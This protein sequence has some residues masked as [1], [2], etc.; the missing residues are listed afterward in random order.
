MMIIFNISLKS[1][2][3]EKNEMTKI[4]KVLRYVDVWK[5]VM[6]WMADRSFEGWHKIVEHTTCSLF[7]CFVQKLF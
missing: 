6:K 7:E 2:A 3:K 1:K 5:F 4:N